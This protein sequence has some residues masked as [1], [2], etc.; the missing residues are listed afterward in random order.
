MSR[1][2]TQ[3]QVA[4]PTGICAATGEP[5]APG[6]T[7]VATLCE[8]EED[9]GFDRRDFALEAWE[10]GARPD[11]LFSHWNMVVPA[12]QERRKLLVDDAVLLDLFE[13]LAGDDRQQRR[14][15]RFILGLILMRK[16]QLRFIGRRREGA[17]E[18]WLMRPRGSDPAAPPL[19]VANPHLCDDDVREL[20]AQLS[21]ILQSELT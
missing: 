7:C 19:E 2:G 10:R 3:Y 15:F 8:R 13:R 9:D 14:A 6:S 5:L 4:R 17:E 11:H 21:E 20:T 1:F 16:R 12:V 18:A